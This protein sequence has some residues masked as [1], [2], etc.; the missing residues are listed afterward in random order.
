MVAVAVFVS[1][2]GFGHAA[3][4]AAVLDA[5]AERRPGLQ[6]HLFTT[7]PRW[8]F[9]ESLAV[10]F[11]YHR[12]VCDVGLVQTSPLDADPAAAVECLEASP[13]NDPAAVA[14]LARRLKAFGCALV[15]ADISP[16]GLRVAARAGLPA[17]LVESFT[18]G[19][20]YDRLPGAPPALRRFG[21]AMAED[22]A[23]AELRVQARPCCEEI[24]GATAV[25]PIARRP[26]QPRES[27]RRLLGIP[28]DGE[29][30]V[31]ASMGGVPW[32]YG[33]LERL[34]AAGAWTVVP[35]GAAR[36]GRHGRLLKLPCHGR[37]YH[38][39]LVAAADAVVGKLGYS[40]A[41]EAMRAGTAFAYLSRPEFPE[42]PVLASFVEARLNAR[43][44]DRE[45]F[46]TGRWLPV[47]TEL[48]AMAPREPSPDDG[49]AAAAAAIL[50]RFP[51]VFG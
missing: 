28:A 4:A 15:I 8:F 10:P 46:A 19:W 26:R 43:K 22:V 25:P 39:D 21:R 12:V 44:L 50:Q 29:P 20:I 3:R 11:R 17:V 18:W 33:P 51:R 30:L 32:S 31:L 23:G 6:I 27:V 16:L 14:R 36:A 34:A 37:F 9:G 40:T 42:S 24:A 49:A 48:L 47:V 38:P 45:N 2:H 35:G 13:W 41:A 5:L 1:P 7:V